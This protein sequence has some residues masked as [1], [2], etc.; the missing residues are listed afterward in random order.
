MLTLWSLQRARRLLPFLTGLVVI[1]MIFQLLIFSKASVLM[2]LIM[3]L[4][5]FLWNKVT[6]KRALV[7]G[8]IVVVAYATLQP[9]VGYARHEIGLRYGA[10]TQAGF[11][12][13]LDIL[14]SYFTSGPATGSAAELQGALS[15]ISYV[16]VATFVIQQYDIGQPGDWPKLLP[17]VFIP[18]ILWPEKPI[19]TQIGVDIYELGTGRTSATFGA[20]VFADAYW[21]MGW[22]G[23]A[24]F[25]PVYGLILGVL[26]IMTARILRDGRWLFFPVVLMALRIGFRTDGH[27]ISDVAGGTV[28]IVAYYVILYVLSVSLKS[29]AK[30]V[31]GT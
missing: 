6:I 18:R 7:C 11:G 9:M 5:A 12:E 19:I 29:L 13:R 8:A 22:W 28:I 23:V 2:I 3:Y 17:A 20:G 25:M 10:N 24:I 26:T 16:N 1:E 31:R 30:P 14:S 15:R 21:A 27:Y 4:L